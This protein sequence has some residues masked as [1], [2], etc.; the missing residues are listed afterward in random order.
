MNDATHPK[1][2]MKPRLLPRSFS[3]LATCLL[4]PVPLQLAG[5]FVIP[6]MVAYLVTDSE[7]ISLTVALGVYVA[8]LALSVWSISLSS[9]G[10]HF[11]RMLGSPKFLAWSEVVSIEVAPQWELIR[12]GWLWP[13]LPAREMTMSLS[14]LGHY[15]IA[16]AKG[17]CYF[18]PSNRE[19]FESYVSKYMPSHTPV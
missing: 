3:D 14:S 10:I 5:L 6:A 19:L 2:V 11:R 16:W 7:V 17:F 1:I 15:R 18:P 8:F 4:V 9:E 12:R 13:L